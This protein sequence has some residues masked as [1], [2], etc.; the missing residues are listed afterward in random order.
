MRAT[1]RVDLKALVD[2]ALVLAEKQVG[3]GPL[4]VCV[5]VFGAGGVL[6]AAAARGS[7][8]DS[9]SGRASGR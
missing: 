5:C 6:A 8:T 4:L 9:G 2:A 1:K 3:R 7:S